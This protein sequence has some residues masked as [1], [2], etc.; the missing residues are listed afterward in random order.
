M[1]HGSNSSTNAF[2]AIEQEP[3][4]L[5]ERFYQEW[6]D[7][8][9]FYTLDGWLTGLFCI[10]GHGYDWDPVVNS[11]ETVIRHRDDWV[12]W[13]SSCER[14]IEYFCSN[15]NWRSIQKQMTFDL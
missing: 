13:Q 9:M 15:Y 1:V 6:L 11:Y 14:E 7:R 2:D 4:P 3:T 12:L 8:S 5:A 10:V